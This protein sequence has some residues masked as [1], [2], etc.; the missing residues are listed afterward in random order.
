MINN[1]NDAKL[2]EF[3]KTRLKDGYCL[4]GE[5]IQEAFWRASQAFADSAAHAARLYS[6]AAD[7]QWFMFATPLLSNGGTKRGLP[8]SCFLNFVDDSRTGLAEHYAENIWL[9][10]SGG[11]IGSDWS[12]VRSVGT[13]TTGGNETTGVMPFMHVA[14]ALALAAN[15]GSTRRGSNA[16]YLDISHP[17][18]EE[19]IRCR[20]AT[21]GNEHRMNRNSHIALNIPDAFMEAVSTDSPWDLIDP[22]SKEVKKTL[23]AKQ[24][25]VDILRERKEQGEP[26]LHFIDESNR[27]L[28]PMQRELGLRINH[29]NLCTEILLATNA[30]RTAV[31]CLSSVNLEKF[32]EW[33]QDT[34]FIEDLMRMLDNALTAFIDDVT[35]GMDKARYSA[36]CER[37]V[38]L[39][40]MGFHSYL[41]HRMIPFESPMAVG[42]NKRIFKHIREKADAANVR[43]GLERGSPPDIEGSG[44]RFSHLLAIAPNA[45]SSIFLATSP[46]IEPV[47][48]NYYL[49]KTL[50]GSFRVV[51]KHLARV[52]E[53]L[54]PNAEDYNTVLADIAANEGSIQHLHLL[55]NHVRDVFKTAPE[56]DQRWVIQHAADRQEFIDQGQSVNIYVPAQTTIKYLNDI[57]VMAW[58]LK[59]KTLYYCRSSALTRASV[60]TDSDCIACEG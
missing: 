60:I 32:D 12:S 2:T 51:N 48:A 31:C 46:G 30:E 35:P 45:T 11:G 28:N 1:S 38:G 58:K 26:Y 57:H 34:F 13:K 21:G 15:Q 6:Y 55:D 25:W 40:A 27:Q 14:D 42:A 24:L 37:S 16:L 39:G 23:R 10:T 8:I 29:S 52:L 19:F 5:T 44:K 22:H 20:R 53:N 3:A 41:Q 17:E 4:E 50:S 36:H 59:L 18:V 7:K 43:L 56:I 9:S 47:P 33:C 54:Y 49:H